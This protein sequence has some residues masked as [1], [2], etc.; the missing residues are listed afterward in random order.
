MS[1]LSQGIRED[2]KAEA[3]AEII[4]NMYKH[5]FTVEQIA[6]VVEKSAE[7]I[8]TIIEKGEPALT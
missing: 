6:N 7:E 8:M 5:G 3:I 2:A 1:N 4:V